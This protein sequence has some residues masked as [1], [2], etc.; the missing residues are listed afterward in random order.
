MKKCLIVVTWVMLFLAGCAAPP[1]IPIS[2]A[3]AAIPAPVTPTPVPPTPT[4]VPPTPTPVPPTPTPIPP[5]PGISVEDLTGVWH[6]T[7]PWLYLLL[8]ENGTFILTDVSNWRK[9]YPSYEGQFRLEGTLLTFIPSDESALC[10]GQTGSYQVEL[11]EEG[12]LQLVLEE[13]QCEGRSGLPAGPWDRVET[14]PGITVE[15]LIGIWRHPWGMYLKLN[16]DGTY[17]LAEIVARLETLP[18]ELGRFELEGRT[19]TFITSNESPGCT[20]QTGS[21]QVELTEQG[22]LR[23]VSLQEDPCQ[24]RADNAPV[25]W[26]RVGPSLVPGTYVTTITQEDS[27]NYSIVGTWDLTLTEDNR[28]SA[29]YLGSVVAEGRYTLTPDEIVFTHEKGPYTHTCTS[30]GAETGKYKW[31]FDGGM[32]TLITI[33]DECANRND[34]WTMHPW[35]KVE[36][37]SGTYVTTITQEDFLGRED[38]HHIAQSIL[39]GE[40]Q[41]T[42]SQGNRYSHDEVTESGQVVAMEEGY[43]TLTRDQMVFTAE[44]GNSAC[45]GPQAQGI[46]QWA[47]DGKTLTLT[48]IE[49]PCPERNTVN[50]A[51]PWSRQD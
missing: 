27:S 21:Y 30:I 41:M 37:P 17:R 13:E 33:E 22:K 45:T 34:V 15:D 28:W 18:S 3:P 44:G 35:S 24:W 36:L 49:D 14:T 42:L 16:E 5:T 47:L 51:H 32:L 43:Y 12:Q 20:G 1:A 23:Y 19:F 48:T 2:G 9:P 50:S 8:N 7:S 25:A 40:W 11:T 26:E 10:A 38:L 6:I 31:A 4:T 46:Y 39:L 29:T